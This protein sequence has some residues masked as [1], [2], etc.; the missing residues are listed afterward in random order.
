MCLGDEVLVG[1]LVANLL[2]NAVRYNRPHGH[3]RVRIRPEPGVVRLEVE[4]DGP[5]IPAERRERVFERF[6]RGSSQDGQ[7]GTGL[8]LAIVRAVCDRIGASVQ[9]ADASSG[10]GLLVT[11][12]F[13]AASEGRS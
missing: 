7:T 2:D 3:V 4:D 12:K 5:G 13:R 1:E 6:Y 8:G 9:L 11:V 10:S